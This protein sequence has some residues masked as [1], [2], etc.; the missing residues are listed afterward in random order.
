MPTIKLEAVTKRYGNTMAADGLNLEI[1]D[2]EY[3]CI[4]GPTGAGK[5]TALRSICGLTEPT[6]GKIFFDGVDVTRLEVEKREAVMLSQIY[7]LFP[8][9]N[10]EEN[11]LFGPKIKEWSEKDCHRLTKSMLNMV[12]LSNR[13]D[14]Y[15]HELSGGMQQRTALARAL[16]SGSKVLLLDEP[17]RALDARLRIELRKELRSLAKGLDLT[18]VHVTHDQD[19]AL[20]M[21]DRI[22]V[23][24][25][26][27]VVQVGTP[28]E[29]FDNPISPFVAN[30]VG[31][32]NF[33]A[34]RIVEK[35]EYTIVQDER[36]VRVPGRPCDLDMGAE[37]VVAVK[38][39]NTRINADEGLLKGT[40][41]RMIYEGTN[42]HVDLVLCDYLRFSVKMPNRKIGDFQVGGQAYIKWNPLEGSVFPAPP[43]GLEAELKVD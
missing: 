41:E 18:C 4:L 2:K 20:V 9:M 5:T 17:L 28:R 3:L 16:A 43:E 39:G 6:G 35:G 22:A 31:Q 37:V 30:F 25:R 32:S 11:V 36:G 12:H 26:G 38:V 14:A 15:P 29:V 24:R 13:A 19:E 21:A 23:L 7:S 33:F 34:G 27:K 8:H 40:I 10:V 1:R 42:V